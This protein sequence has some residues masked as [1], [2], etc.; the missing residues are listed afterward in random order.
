LINLNDE[1][2]NTIKKLL[3]LLLLSSFAPSYAVAAQIS[4]SFDRNPVSVDESFQIIFTANDTPDNDPDFSPLEQDFEIL[5]QTQS[6]NSSWIN[7]RSSKSIQW[8]LNVVAKHPGSLVVPEV[9]F[10]NDLSQPASILVTQQGAAT[11]DVDTD[12]DLF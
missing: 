6:S 10:G 3:F 7:G 5:G 2:M 1:V 12:E 11:K 9:P 4:V 8:T